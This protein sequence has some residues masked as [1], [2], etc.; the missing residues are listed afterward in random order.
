M[1]A[2]APDQCGC[3]WITVHVGRLAVWHCDPIYERDRSVLTDPALPGPHP[4]DH[5]CTD[6]LRTIGPESGFGYYCI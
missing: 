1:V 6:A 4:C 2:E 5:H 3:Q